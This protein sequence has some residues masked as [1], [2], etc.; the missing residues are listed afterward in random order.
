MKESSNKKTGIIQG[1]NIFKA[2]PWKIYS[3]SD[4]DNFT[5]GFDKKLLDFSFEP[6]ISPTNYKDNRLYINRVNKPSNYD[7]KDKNFSLFIAS[8][9]NQ[10]SY[11]KILK[12]INSFKNLNYNWD[13]Y[14][15]EKTTD[16]AINIAKKVAD[17][18][19][20]NGITIDICVPMRDGGIQFD[21]DGYIYDKE[22]EIHPNG[23]MNLVVYNKDAD[24]I[25]SK[26]ASINDITKLIVQYE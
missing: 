20:K 23:T 10:D 25:D 2:L 24:I 22:I 6:S 18:I 8:L 26:P 4:Y 12:A 5:I 7:I 11:S 3:T 14:D 13:G 19:I 1:K 17:K 21:M 16:T 15:A 9:K